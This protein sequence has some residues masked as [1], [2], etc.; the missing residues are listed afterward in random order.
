MKN[1]K[2]LN[3]KQQSQINGGAFQ[4][5]SVTRPCFI[6]FCC[7]GVCMEYDCIE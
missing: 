6:G 7:Q 3:R 1:L 2:K 4:K 5:C